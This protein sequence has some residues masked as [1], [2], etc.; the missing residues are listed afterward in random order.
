MQLINDNL[1]VTAVLLLLVVIAEWLGQR[2]YF[3][4]LGSTL[5]VIIVAAILANVHLL[6]SSQDVSVVYDGI[7]AYAAPL[8]IFFLL[9]DVRLK[10]LR[11]AGLPM[12]VMFLAGAA[13]SVTGVLLGYYFIKPQ[14]HGVQSAFAVAGMYTG[15]Y[16]GGSANLN[17][18]A[19]TYGVNKDGTLF[20]AI[21]AADNIITT[22]WMIVTIFLPSL[23]QK[24]F[25]RKQAVTA[26][27]SLYANNLNTD[28]VKEEM[29]ILGI[30]LLLFLGV[31]SLF[32]SLAV[33]KLVPKIP[34][35]LALTTMALVLAQMPFVHKLKGGKIFGYFLVLLFLAVVGAYCDIHALVSNGSVALTLL[36]WVTATVFIHGILLF[37]LGAIFKQDW[38]IISIASNANIGGA[39]TA[40]ALAASLGRRDLRLPGILVGSLGTALGTYLGIIIA[41]FLR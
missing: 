13:F 30:G 39:T 40:A 28:T 9:L 34:S 10:D 27:V 3:H 21:N 38:Y 2:K 14:L 8:G 1:Y 15:T 11:A 6:P 16:T 22:V 18:V 41:E 25:P 29:S 32:V 35:I 37:L 36:V 4:Y 5:I 24:W 33:T 17:A 23:L 12:V 19:I 7:F 20:A 31:A 26:D